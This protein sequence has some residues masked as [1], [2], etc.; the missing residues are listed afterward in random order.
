MTSAVHRVTCRPPRA[1][2]DAWNL[3]LLREVTP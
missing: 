2:T 1:T 3:I